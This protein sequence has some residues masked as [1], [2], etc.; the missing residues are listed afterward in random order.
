MF[1][2]F[3]FAQLLWYFLN[4]IILLS[5]FCPVMPLQHTIFSAMN[6]FP[7]HLGLLDFDLQRYF[8]RQAKLMKK[9]QINDTPRLIIKS[10]GMIKIAVYLWVFKGI[11][12]TTTS[13]NFTNYHLTATASVCHQCWVNYVIIGGSCNGF[14]FLYDLYNLTESYHLPSNLT[15]SSKT[16]FKQIHLET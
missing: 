5:Y 12:S 15:F 3:C 9:V 4:M 6:I 13:I 1:N 11:N 16:T 2:Y 7:G 10:H 8:M 14:L